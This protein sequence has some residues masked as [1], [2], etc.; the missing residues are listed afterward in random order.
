MRNILNMLD[1]IKTQIQ[2][3]QTPKLVQALDMRDEVI[4]QIQLGQLLC[5]GRGGFDS[6]DLILPE[7]EFLEEDHQSA[8][9]ASYTICGPRGRNR[10]LQIRK[11]LQA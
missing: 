3:R 10:Y 2:N 6:R 1:L 4:I 5:S 9:T 7:A 11:P 8:F